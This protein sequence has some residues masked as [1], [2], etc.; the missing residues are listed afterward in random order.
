MLSLRFLPSTSQPQ[1][2]MSWLTYFFLPDYEL[3]RGRDL[4]ILFTAVPISCHSAWFTDLSKG[5]LSEWPH[6]LWSVVLAAVL[7]SPGLCV[8]A[9]NGLGPF[10]VSYEISVKEEDTELSAACMTE[11]CS[12]PSQGISQKLLSLLLRKSLGFRRAPKSLLV[13]SV[14]DCQWFPSAAFFRAL[15]AML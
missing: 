3:L 14:T 13:Q 12:C 10:T 1:L 7:L 8:T 15:F 9:A 11:G 4:L 2:P 5:L 6:W